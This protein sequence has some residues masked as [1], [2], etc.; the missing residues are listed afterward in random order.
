MC[1]GIAAK[2]E[3]FGLSRMRKQARVFVPSMGDYLRFLDPS[4]RE[5]NV[6]LL[7]ESFKMAI[8]AMKGEICEIDGD[9]VTLQDSVIDRW[10][11]DRSSEQAVNILRQ[12]QRAFYSYL[13]KG[14][15]IYLS[16]DL[17][18]REL[19]EP[20][21]VGLDPVLVSGK[22]ENP[23]DCLFLRTSEG[24]APFNQSAS[25]GDIVAKLRPGRP[26]TISPLAG[27]LNE[28]VLVTAGKE[29][30]VAKKFTDWHG[31]KWFTLNLVS[32]GSKVFAVSGKA[33]MT[34]EYGINRYLAKKGLNVPQIIHVDLK[35]RIL[36]EKYVSGIAL[37]DF[38]IQAVNQSALSEPQ[39]RL[40]ES[41]GETLGRIHAIGVAVG[42]AKPENFVAKDDEVFTVDLEQAGK[43]ED[44]AWD[45]AELLFYTGHYSASPTPTL[46]LNEITEAVA[47]GY[48]HKGKP[49]HLKQAAALRYAKAFSFWTPAPIIYQISRTLQEAGRTS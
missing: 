46:G 43:R 17:I 3:F 6:G 18:A 13:T 35:H 24:F 39:R 27:V 1:R 37:S 16:L 10:L 30:F 31:F 25:F 15:S 20:L 22:P 5:G 23:K 26:I 49:S 44:F 11:K 47:K 12:S 32:F 29:Q 19:S 45:I 9:Y 41:L 21:R 7:C 42:D 8:S 4:V 40:A 33:R 2:P 34:N 38:M 36:V 48:L 14:R 28:V